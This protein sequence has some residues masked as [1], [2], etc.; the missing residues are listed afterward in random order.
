MG[1]SNA[2]DQMLYGGLACLDSLNTTQVSIW[3]LCTSQPTPHL[4]CV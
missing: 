1:A 3:M 2:L 4:P